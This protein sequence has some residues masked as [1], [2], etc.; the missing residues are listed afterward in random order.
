MKCFRDDRI[1]NNN[2]ILYEIEQVLVV[3]MLDLIVSLRLIRLSS[4]LHTCTP[5][6]NHNYIQVYEKT[7][8][9]MY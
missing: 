1:C 6:Y 8:L 5:F 9:E 3:I 7:G 2:L 4:Y